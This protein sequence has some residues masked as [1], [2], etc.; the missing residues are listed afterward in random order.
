MAA[1]FQLADSLRRGAIGK[2]KACRHTSRGRAVCGLVLAVLAALAGCGGPKYTFAEVEGKVTLGEK[3][4]RGVIVTF[5]PDSEGLGAVA[6]LRGTTDDTGTYT[7]T[8]VGGKPG[9]LVGNNRVVVNW[10]L[11]ERRSDGPRPPRRA[12]RSRSRTRW[13]RRPRSVSR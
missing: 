1:S 4:L 3:P 12:R 6:V 10:P 8:A 2:L 7:L 5:Y 9:A 13:P 11:P